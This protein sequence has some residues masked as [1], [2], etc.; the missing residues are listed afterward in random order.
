MKQ[1]GGHKGPKASASTRGSQKFMTIVH[2]MAYHRKYSNSGSN[3]LSQVTDQLNPYPDDFTFVVDLS[4]GEDHE[5]SLRLGI[6]CK[7]RQ[8][9]V[10]V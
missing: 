9:I 10:H 2:C 8:L 3:E 1:S 6:T 5:L 4:L 7:L